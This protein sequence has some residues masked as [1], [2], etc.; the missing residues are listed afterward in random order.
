MHFANT[1]P[2]ITATTK[3]AI[4]ILNF[5]GYGGDCAKPFFDFGFSNNKE[6][7]KLIENIRWNSKYY[8][9]KACSG[10]FQLEFLYFLR[11]RHANPS[12]IEAAHLN[13]IHIIA[14]PISDLRV[15]K[16]P[17]WRRPFRH[18]RQLKTSTEQIPYIATRSTAK[19]EHSI[20]EIDKRRV[21]IGG[22][23]RRSWSAKETWRYTSDG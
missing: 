19:T 12:T 13:L 16:S 6:N 14:H 4:M 8:I 11:P 7:F 2:N 17:S 10:Y 18:R 21:P 5:Q 1:I 3:I 15:R 20:R 22:R 9:K 23:I